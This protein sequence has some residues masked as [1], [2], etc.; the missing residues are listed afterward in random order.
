ME[1]NHFVWDDENPVEISF[2]SNPTLTALQAEIDRVDEALRRSPFFS[3]ADAFNPSQVRDSSGKWTSGGGGG[4]GGGYFANVN[5]P[6]GSARL[7]AMLDSGTVTK[8]ALLAEPG[9]KVAY[10]AVS[11]APQTIHQPGFGSAEYFN[12]REY[13]I[14][15]DGSLKGIDAAV[16]YLYEQS[17]VLA[18]GDKKA[19]ALPVER[20]FQ[21]TIFTGAPASGKSTVADPH[22]RA[23]RARIID[24]DEAKKVIP[25]FGKGE[26]VSAVHEESGYLIDHVYDRATSRGDNIV[27]PTV[28]GSAAK[29]DARVR[30]LQSRGYTVKVA[31]VDT[32][33][34]T[35]WERMAGRW[36]TTGRLIPPNYM[37]Q[38]VHA[39]VKSFETQ[40]KTGAANAYAVIDNN[41]GRDEPRIVKMGTVRGF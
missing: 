23:M 15:G 41:P 36:V 28:G 18:Y 6:Y 25:E 38:A 11:N 13:G 5:T 16:D 10:E 24:S 34:E 3:L 27:I 8:E 14:E 20:G 2:P 26:G 21:A 40:V 37:E 30:D 17:G 7:R 29:I 32:A 35:A 22:A 33:P 19:E 1:S 12:S 31:L 39:P 4:G 9:F